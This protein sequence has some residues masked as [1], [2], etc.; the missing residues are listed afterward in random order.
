M[1]YNCFYLIFS[2]HTL[3]NLSVFGTDS[4]DAYTCAEGTDT[5]FAEHSST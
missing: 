1:N 4:M 5:V 2:F 3:V